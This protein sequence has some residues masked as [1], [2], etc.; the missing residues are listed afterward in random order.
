MILTSL[1]IKVSLMGVT[2]SSYHDRFRVCIVTE[3]LFS[4]IEERSARDERRDF[5][6]KFDIDQLLLFSLKTII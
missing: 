3:E 6:T 5:V 1:F 4:F 2:D